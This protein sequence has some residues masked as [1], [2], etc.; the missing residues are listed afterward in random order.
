LVKTKNQKIG[1]KIFEIKSS[2]NELG[3]T[4]TPEAEKIFGQNFTFKIVSI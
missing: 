3:I 2:F 1:S 4:L